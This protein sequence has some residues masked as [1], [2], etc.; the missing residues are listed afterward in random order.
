MMIIF[1][2]KF[3]Y[4]LLA[5]F[6]SLSCH[7][8]NWGHLLTG[9]TDVLKKDQ[10]TAGTLLFAGGVSEEVTVGFS[11]FAY[12]VYN[13]SNLILRD[14][15]YHGK[16]YTLAIDVMLFDSLKDHHSYYEQTSWTVRM[17]NKLKFSN[18]L[19][20]YGSLGVQYFINEK[21]PYSFRPD[22]LGRYRSFMP[23]YHDYY[24]KRLVDFELY[25]RDPKT[26]SL[27]VMPEI[28]LNED[29]FLNLEY[30]FLGINYFYPL[31][32]F[33]GSLNYQYSSFDMGLGISRSTRKT[34]ML[35]IETVDHTEGKLQFYF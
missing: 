3:F 31:Q 24:E 2:H 18:D 32:H 34:P 15:L 12:L 25:H 5:V 17:N 33:G 13:F 21:S 4:G 23:K 22:P 9:T 11:P 14:Q 27:S 7:A 16:N 35:G 1:S 10:G 30:G 8:M 26:V 29:F 28:F 19:S 20:I 6:F